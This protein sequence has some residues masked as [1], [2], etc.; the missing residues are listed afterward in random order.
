MRL[1]EIVEINQGIP[2]SRIRVKA[3]MESEERTVYSFEKESTALVPKN[4]EEVD[5]NIPLADENMILFNMVSY[6]AKRGM[7][8]DIGKIIPSNYVII[9]LR[10]GDVDLDY[11]AWYMDQSEEFKR[12]L[13]KLQQG[14]AVLSLPINEF[15]KMRIKLPSLEFQNKMGSL[16]RLNR[17]RERL[18]RERQYLIEKSMIKINEGELGN[19]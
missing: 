14:S 17:K 7:E 15:R 2:L 11:L 8:D 9:T 13:F 1:E 16:S 18:F 4:I 6:T 12:E 5:Q 19:G 3:D 10:S